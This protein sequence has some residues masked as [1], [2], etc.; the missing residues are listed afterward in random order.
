MNLIHSLN[1][2]LMNSI[3]YSSEYNNCLPGPSQKSSASRL[4]CQ[5]KCDIY[6]IY[7]N[8]SYDSINYKLTLHQ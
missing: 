1:K 5:K 6:H 8:I 7:S 4:K 3:I 2:T